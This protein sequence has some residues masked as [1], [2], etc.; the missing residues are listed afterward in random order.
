MNQTENFLAIDLGASHGRAVLG[1]YNGKKLNLEVLHDFE[2]GGVNIN[3]N[4]YWDVLKQFNEIKNGLKKAA[5]NCNLNSIG[6][7]TWGVDYALLDQSGSLISN[8]Y[9]YRDHRT[10]NIMTEVFKRISKEKIYQKTGN[11]FLQLNTLF[12]LYADK[13]MRPWM[14]E[15]AADLLFIPDLMNYFFTGEKY[16]EHTIA[17]T[18]QLFNP[19]I[20]CWEKDIFRTLD[21]NI[22]I[23]Q[24]IIYP[25]TKIGNILKS[26]T[27]ELNI[28]YDIPVIAVG[29]H[30]T[31]SAV[32]AAPISPENSA[33]ISS[34]TWSLLGVELDNVIINEQSLENNFTNEIGLQRKIRF[35]KNLTGLWLIQKCKKIWNK[36]NKNLTYSKINK[37]AEKAEAYLFRINP[38]HHD[39]LNPNNMVKAV[40]NY[41]KSTEQYVP[42]SIGEIARGIYESLAFKYAEEIDKLEKIT[43]KKIDYVNIVGGGSSA[44]LICQYT[45]NLSQKV[46]ISGPIEAAAAGNILAQ[47][48]RAGEIK[49]LKEEN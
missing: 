46:V 13:L 45:A 40:K 35:L 20:N 42:K 8:P 21:L 10:D 26:I 2:N 5:E 4:L 34:G 9:H 49:N 3:G 23:M 6:I 22:D 7:D 15:N 33:Y 16:N 14:I 36:N 30:D 19:Q 17:S 11:Q 44:E 28:K 1:K 18:S 43:D 29:S 25:G 37:A 31:A 38:D 47:L 39:F 27:S 24:K 12:Q 48:M 41:C 32:A